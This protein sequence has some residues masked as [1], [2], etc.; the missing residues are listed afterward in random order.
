M[1]EKRITML[2]GIKMVSGVSMFDGSPF[3]QTRAVDEEGN[4]MI[5]QLDPTE[6]RV[7]GQGCF[8]AAEAAETDA[9]IWAL[10]Q[11]AGID[12]TLTAALLVGLRE[13]R[14]KEE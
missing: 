2:A 12:E 10:G 1:T 4:E 7:H 8:E 3:I 14:E 6:L 5:G 11:E 13:K 9:L